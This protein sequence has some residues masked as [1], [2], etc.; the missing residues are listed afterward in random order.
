MRRQHR[1]THAT[2]SRR[3]RQTQ[4]PV[5]TARAQRYLNTSTPARMH[6]PRPGPCNTHAHARSPSLAPDHTPAATSHGRTRPGTPTAAGTADHG[7]SGLLPAAKSA[8]ALTA[9]PPSG[10]C[11]HAPPI[12][13]CAWRAGCVRACTGGPALVACSRLVLGGFFEQLRVDASG[14]VCRLPLCAAHHT[15]APTAPSGPGG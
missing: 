6:A 9:T 7:S 10:G 15:A 2:S 11:F 14:C 1:N 12:G 5:N 13:G 4:Q 8:A 3:R